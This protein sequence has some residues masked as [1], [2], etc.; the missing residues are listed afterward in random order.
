MTTNEKAE[1]KKFPS[2][3]NFNEESFLLSGISWQDSLLQAY[4]NYMVVTQSVFIAAGI[5]LLNSQISETEIIRKTTFFIPF[6]VVSI[7]GL[8]TLN[9]LR[10]ALNERAKSVDWWQKRLLKYEKSHSKIRHFTTFRTA[11]EHSFKSPEIEAEVLSQEDIDSLLRPDKPKARI[12]FGLFIPG[13]F[14]LWIILI[15]SSIIDFPWTE[16]L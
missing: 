2:T 5:V 15:I 9:F 11:K 8:L 10:G 13:F 14:I 16:I 3:E 1:N 6:I 7:I 12:V 4:R